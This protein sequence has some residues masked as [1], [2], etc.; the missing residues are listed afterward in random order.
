MKHTTWHNCYDENLKDLITPESFSHPAKLSKRLCERIIEHGEA[1]GYWRR[2]DLI[3]DPFAGIFTV[4]ILG[5]YRGYRVVGVELEPRFFKMSNDNIDLNRRKLELLGCPLPIVVQGDSRRLVE[6][7]R[8]IFA[9][10][11]YKGDE[12]VPVSWWEGRG[13]GVSGVVSSPPYASSI[14]DSNGIDASKLTGNPVGPHSQAFA[15]GYGQSAGQIGAMREG[16]VDAVISSPPFGSSLSRDVIDPAARRQ[17]ARAHGISNSERVTPVDMERAGAR[18]QEYGDT[19]GQIG[20]MR[21]GPGARYDFITH[22]PDNAHIQ[23]SDAAYGVAD[24]QIGIMR[25]GSIDAVISS[26]PYADSVNATHNG[27]DWQKANRPDR[28]T[29]SD[30]RHNPMSTGEMNYG[31]SDGQI[32]ALHDAGFDQVIQ[33]PSYDGSVDGSVFSPPFSPPG[34]QPVI[35]Q[36]TRAQLKTAGRSPLDAQQTQT[37][38]NIADLTMEQSPSFGGMDGIDA[39]ISSPPY[40]SGGHHPDQ[41]GAWGGQAQSVDRDLAGYGQ[42]TGQI[43]Q[44]SEGNFPISIEGEGRG[45]G[46]IVDA[47]LTS[48]PYEEGLGHGG[49]P[50]PTDIDKKLYIAALNPYGTTSGNIGNESKETYWSA[51][52]TVY[53]QLYTVLKPGGVAAIVIKDFVRAKARVPLCDQTARLLEALGFTVIERTRAM[54]VKELGTSTDMFTGQ[55]VN[56]RVERKSFFR[57]LYERNARAE[58]FWS[59]IGRDM[60]ARYLVQ[61]HSEAWQD[62]TDSATDLETLRL[63]QLAPDST[64]EEIAEA[65]SAMEFYPPSLPT[66]VKVKDAAIR[67]AYVEHGSPAIDIATAINF[68]EILW[69]QKPASV[70]DGVG[71]AVT[72]PPYHP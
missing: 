66:R 65:A 5:A 8:E 41:T 63:I 72:S 44:L 21:E 31:Q 54:L 2:G 48:P 37:A 25:A 46:D 14:H 62:Y 42:T 22:S 49:E 16:D 64:A 57:R 33:P 45:E 26:P 39:A 36:G 55:L 47:A 1:Q 30:D 19:D 51:M 34:N 67:L 24:G 15:E 4:G 23:T 17:W 32:G 61:A 20:I 59:T 3:L 69:A 56:H 13:E 35:G 71:R 11:P 60:Q 50:T 58:A 9:P 53:R 40:V 29:E 7:V 70:G 52:S 27:I 68:E 10:S 43:G 12:T 28:L 38:G 18:D 6:I